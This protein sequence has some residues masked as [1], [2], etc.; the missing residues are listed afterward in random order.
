MSGTIEGREAEVTRTLVRWMQAARE[1]A[2]A[3]WGEAA[4]ARMSVVRWFAGVFADHDILLTPTAPCD[5]PAASGPLPTKVAD[6]PLPAAGLAAFTMP[7]NF[8]WLPAATVRAGFSQSG[9]PVGLQIVAPRGADDPRPPG[10]ARVR[11]SL[12]LAPPLAERRVTRHR[13]QGPAS[14]RTFRRR[15]N[16]R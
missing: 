9:L 5:P 2:P 6:S 12:P 13:R 1:A 3:L 16:A 8:A 4:R 10:S 11:N 15:P 7:V 14:I